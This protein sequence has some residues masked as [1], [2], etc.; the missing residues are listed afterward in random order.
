M[1]DPNEAR[2]PSEEE[3]IPVGE[4]RS[5]APE[6]S[7]PAQ[8]SRT[9]EEE[10]R[11]PFDAA[12]DRPEGRS[13][14]DGVEPGPWPGWVPEPVASER[15]DF[16]DPHAPPPPG[17]GPAGEPWGA[18]ASA[19]GAPMDGATGYPAGPPPA[20]YAY[21]APEG[22]G[23]SG[24]PGGPGWPADTAGQ[25]PRGGS[26][27]PHFGVL[28]VLAVVIAVVAALVG[29]GV[30]GYVVSR[31]SGSNFHFDSPPSGG[32]QRS[33]KSIAGVAQR[34]RPSVVDIKVSDGGS[35]GSGGGVEG[36]GFLV[37]DGYIITN[38]HVISGAV[39]GGQVQVTY[40]DGAKTSA[41]I[42]GHDSSYD[43]AVLKPKE[44]GKRTPLRLG[45]SDEMMVGDPVIAV[46]SPLGLAG[47]VTTGIIS[48]KD[49]PVAAGGGRGGQQ[50]YINALQTDAAIN[51]GNSGGPLV[52][53]KGQVIGVNTAIAS[54]SGNQPGQ[55]SGS[56]GLGFAI[57]VNQARRVAEQLIKTGK[58]THPVIGAYIDLTYKGQGARL[59]PDSAKG[60]GI[61]KG[62]PAEKAGLKSG[63]IITKIDSKK[64]KSADQLLVEIRSH[65][66]G[67]VV[68]ITYQ[69]NGGEHTV[70]LTLGKK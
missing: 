56:I 54:A 55:Q 17:F 41:K 68:K 46:G 30:G 19:M 8:E 15:P 34:V 13:G 51:H 4:E 65:K 49:R 60:H 3:H 62:G 35:G 31:A 36:S 47:T 38:N 39:G 22:P 57:P 37:K 25:P 50:S 18:S 16:H 33:P 61:I 64:I 48:A 58:A 28:I 20:G 23:M 59:V 63:D 53:G 12:T 43:I 66:P 11:T 21:G 32:K 40:G 9:P 69:R 5:P 42:V 1:S 7:T 26:R 67:E 27:G 52:D 14:A 10:S 70:K 2:G 6:D 24:P 29:G 44:V 45:N